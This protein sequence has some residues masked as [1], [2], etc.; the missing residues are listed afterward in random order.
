MMPAVSLP[1]NALCSLVEPQPTQFALQLQPPPQASGLADAGPNQQLAIQV[2]HARLATWDA[3][4]RPSCLALNSQ[5]HLAFFALLH[6][7]IHT[8][9]PAH[10]CLVLLP[11]KQPMAAAFQGSQQASALAQLNRMPCQPQQLDGTCRLWEKAADMQWLGHE[12]IS[13]RPFPCSIN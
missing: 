13:H 2:A 9:P 3:L 8:R 1:A 10:C 11:F 4:R 12:H 5:S 6:M 7:H